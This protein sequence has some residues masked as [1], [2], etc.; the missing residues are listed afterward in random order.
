MAKNLPRGTSVVYEASRSDQFFTPL[1]L[2]QAFWQRWGLP[3]WDPATSERNPLQA[4]RWTTAGG[5][6]ALAAAA[7]PSETSADLRNVWCNP[8]YGRRTP[9]W[10]TALANLQQAD[11]RTQVTL[12]VPCRPGAAWYAA[13]T[14]PRCSTAAQAVCELRGRLTYEQPSGLPHPFPARWASALI[15]W[16]PNRRSWVAWA[17]QFGSTRLVRRLPPALT[18]VSPNQL[19]LFAPR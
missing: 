17:R 8:P 1:W 2:R 9:L 12:L 13:A 6:E 16:G 4:A 10:V 15:Y 11:P 18:N 19:K 5:L 7:L 3:S 14:D